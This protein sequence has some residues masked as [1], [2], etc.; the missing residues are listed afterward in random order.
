[1]PKI[2]RFDDEARHALAAGVHILAQAVRGTLGPKGRFVVLDRPIGRPLVTND[3]A[4]I[5][6]E[7]ELPDRFLNM[8]VQL[9]REAAAQTNEIAGDGTT[10]ATLL[11]DALVQSA[12]GALAAGLHPVDLSRH[13]DTLAQDAKALLAEQR[14]WL[15]TADEVRQVACL[16]AGDASLGHLIAEAFDRLGSEAHITLDLHTG[17]DRLQYAGGMQFDRGYVSH[18]MA[19]DPRRNLAELNDAALLLTDQTLSAGPWFDDLVDSLVQAQIPGLLLVAEDYAAELVSRCITVKDRAPLAV[20]A[21]RAPEFGPWRKAALEDL[22]IFTGG[23]FFARDLGV[24]PTEASAA[25]LGRAGRIVVTH[26]RIMI[27]DGRGSPEAIEGRKDAIREQLAVTEQPFERDKLT[28]RLNRLAGNSATLWI[29]GSTPLE[30]KA[31]MGRAEDALHAVRSALLSG[32]VLGGGVSLL[33]TA[34]ALR[35]LPEPP[36]HNPSLE[37]AREVFCR[38]L[39]EPAR[40]LAE[41]VGVDP[42]EALRYLYGHPGHGLNALTGTY[43]DFRTQC[44]FDPLV[45]L[46]EALA[47]ALS[48]AKLILNTTVLVSD[49]LDA[50]DPTE[51][52]ARGGG[53]ELLGMN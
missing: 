7:I 35:Q 31:R 22:A 51:G 8:G 47:N 15:K 13:L 29:G 43:E 23:R 50:G 9:A 45:S 52:P 32:V 19:T 5:A 48:V 24:S 3:G 41:N 44:I 30:Q 14:F 46:T 11:A 6:E 16:A 27:Q 37:M 33:A 42:D 49:V 4:A 28:E 38:A 40:A 17:S 12:Q 20:V 10:T 1:M 25:E 36:Q 53:G 18:H 26:D 2:L 39:E 21:V 34:Q